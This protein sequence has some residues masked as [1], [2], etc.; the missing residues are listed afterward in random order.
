M[1]KKLLGWQVVLGAC[2]VALS[3]L[4]YGAHFLIW[5]DSHH[6]FIYL[7]GDIAFVPLEV[8]LV[9]LILHKLLEVHEKRSILGKLNMVIGA[10]FS[11]A[12]TEL[13]ERLSAFDPQSGSLAERLRMAGKW[14]RR[15]FAA[16]RREF[17]AAEHRLDASR[18]RIMDLKEFLV[19]RRG[20][21]LGLLENPNLLEHEH[22][23]EMLWAVF[24]LTAELA[25]RGDLSSLGEKD[26]LH[27]AGDMRRAYGA[28]LGEWLSYMAHLK[29]HYPYLFSLAV[30]TNPF[31]P[32]ARPEV[33]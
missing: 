32:E 12:G 24:H 8:L 14:G 31:D 18:G 2:L 1:L 13:L 29:E 17:A 3:A 15:E 33:A 27:L 23:T 16:A 25:H 5:H 10:F 6:I 9:A 20:F 11:E 22:F 26:L 19:S 7:V 4:F 28:V 21:L 30:R